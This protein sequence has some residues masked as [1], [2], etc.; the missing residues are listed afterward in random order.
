MLGNPLMASAGL[1]RLTHV[2]P[3]VIIT[4]G[5]FPAQG[6]QQADQR[7]KSSSQINPRGPCPSP[8][9]FPGVSP[10][11]SLQ[12]PSLAENRVAQFRAKVDSN[13][14]CTETADPGLVLASGGILRQK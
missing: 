6:P 8:T 14:F 5:S 13:R 3:V 12:W 7:R 10:A 9:S 4:G 11:S 2:A 1:D